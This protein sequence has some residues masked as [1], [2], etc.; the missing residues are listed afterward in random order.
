MNLARRVLPSLSL[1]SVLCVSFLA[2]TSAT[3]E[4]IAKPPSTTNVV[5]TGAP[6]PTETAPGIVPPPT[7]T[8]TV[9]LDSEPGWGIA[10][11]PAP[12]YAE[13]V[14]KVVGMTNDAALRGA[15]GRRGLNVLNVMWEDTGRSLGS[16]AGPNISDLTLQVRY[17][18]QNQNRAAL[19][20][21]IRFPNFTDR[22]GDI[23][24]DRFL[25]RVGNQKK[26]GALETV[27]LADVL[28]DIRK[29]VSDPGS[30]L[31]SGNLSAARDTHYLASA[32][33]V[34]LP[35]PKE[36]RAEFTPVLFNYQ[37]FPESPA[38]ATLLVTRQ[39][40]SFTV[41]ENDGSES[42]PIASSG[43]ELYFNQ[44]GERAPFTA[45]R[46]TDV[47]N[48]IEA[49]GGPKSE[50]DVSALARGADVL[51]IVQIP[52]RQKPRPRFEG[53][54]APSSPDG[55]GLV[56]KSAGAPP[57]SSPAS[58]AKPKGSA[59]SKESDVEQAV[60][61]HGKVEGKFAEG[62][63]RKLERDPRFPVR[64]T[65]Q[66]YKAT[67]NG[68][69]SEADLDAIAR[70]IGGV[71]EHADFVGSLVVPEGDPRRPTAWQTMPAGWFSW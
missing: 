67:S 63:A 52:L 69:V 28:K 68:V 12:T 51:F 35:I 14:N 29:Y 54:W 70:T 37:S 11:P 23:P 62:R 61:G 49:Q 40:T 71:Y 5:A 42:S 58:M 24:A 26:S 45:E 33:A 47:K 22:T 32:Q 7:A 60:L 2:C 6:A 27:A 44:G 3:P 43:Q 50:D 38:V 25:I 8:A 4:P 39:G 16:S 19:L 41:I 48:R 30:V 59:P 64:V 55:G 46:R 13:V 1:A 31:G 56:M 9:A 15:V 65:V 20:P 57:A 10:P 36:G 34:F 18:E 66:F 17:R 53:N 21:V